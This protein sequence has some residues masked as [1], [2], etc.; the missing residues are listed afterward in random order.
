M[1]SILFP[2]APAVKCQL[3]RIY[4]KTKDKALAMRCQVVMMAHHRRRRLEISRIT[5]FSPSWVWRILRRFAQRGIAALYDGREDNGQ[6]KADEAF[7]RQLYVVVDGSP[8]DYGYPRPTWTQE[9]LCKVM[10]RC[11]G[12]R[13]CRATM[14]RALSRIGARHGRPKPTVACPWSKSARSRR[15]R[16]LQRLVQCLADDEALFYE[17]EVDIHLNPKI[18]PDWMNRGKQKWVMTPGQN[19]KR[20]LAGAL[21]A[22]TGVVLW[23]ES[24]RK[25]TAVF[26]DLLKH[27]VEA[28]R[29]AKVIH[30]ILDNYRIHDSR[31]AQAAVAVWA[32]K[33]RLHFLPPYCPDDNRIERVWLD[34]HANVTRN[35]RCRSMG[36]LM[37]AV[38]RY[39]RKRNARKRCEALPQMAQPQLQRSAA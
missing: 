21:D 31:A 19:Q 35:H 33:I 6:E 39:L 4:R 18:G 11:R 10:Y 38:R 15:Q 22:R 16:L 7:L 12:V 32:G 14:S 34:V 1:S 24:D 5:G 13:V 2:L 29:H 9:L 8:Q 25:N 26:V 28:H 3:R 30:V 36:Q 20:Y 27:L 23:R 17:D 37:A